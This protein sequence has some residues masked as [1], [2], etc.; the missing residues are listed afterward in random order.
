VKAVFIYFSWACFF[1][2]IV[3]VLLALNHHH[4]IFLFTDD[5]AHARQADL[6]HA[7]GAL[8]PTLG[9][10][11]ICL[12]LWGKSGMR[13]LTSQLAIRKMNTQAWLFAL[14]PFVYLLIALPIDYFIS[15]KW[16]SWNEYRM[17]NELNDPVNLF[18]WLLPSLFYGIFEEPGWRGFLLPWLQKRFSAMN[19]TIILTLFWTG[20]HIPSFFYRYHLSAPMIIGFIIGLFAGAVVLTF[21]YNYTKG[22]LLA[23][24]IWHLTWDIVSIAGKD[25]NLAAIMSTIIMVIAVVILIVYK[26]KNLSP[27]PPTTIADPIRTG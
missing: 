15:N 1:S 19:A 14:S 26:W 16:F 11:I 13:K 20:W 23:V 5:A 27:Y 21:L 12:I 9:A 18:Y 6:C 4:V 17:M 25:G 7:F 2:W 10:V 3:F 24:I 22:S 8:G